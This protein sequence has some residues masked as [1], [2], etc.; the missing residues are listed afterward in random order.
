MTDCN[1]PAEWNL[2]LLSL[3]ACCWLVYNLDDDDGDEDNESDDSDYVV[4]GYDMMKMQKK[5]REKM[6]NE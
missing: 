1:P 4:D 5:A 3:T 2:L 6:M